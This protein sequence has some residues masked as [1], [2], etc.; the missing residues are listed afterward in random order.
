MMIDMGSERFHTSL[1]RLWLYASYILLYKRFKTRHV[2]S[3]LCQMWII[4][5]EAIHLFLFSSTKE[6]LAQSIL[7][8]L[9]GEVWSSIYGLLLP[10][11]T[12][13]HVPDTYLNNEVVKIATYI[14]T[15]LSSYAV[16]WSRLLSN[17][18]I[19]GQPI[20]G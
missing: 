12:W 15:D 11:N 7:I 8:S 16:V 18:L 1:I 5:L 13:I 10:L 19:D 6:S 3:F 4:W 2:S 20:M 17:L 14:K 9:L